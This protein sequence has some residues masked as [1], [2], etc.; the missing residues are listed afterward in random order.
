MEFRQVIET[1][2]KVV[3][4]PTKLANEINVPKTMISD[5]KAGR[6]GLPDRACEKLAEI[7]KLDFGDVIRARMRSPFA[8][9]AAVILATAITA[10]FYTP[11]SYADEIMTYDSS[12]TYCFQK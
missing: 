2:E 1:A 9:H 4:G 3:G 10:N 8:K 11:E 7:A 12:A 5:A 6:R